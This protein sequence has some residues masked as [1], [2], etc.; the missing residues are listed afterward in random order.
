MSS[1]RFVACTLNLWGDMRLEEREPALRAFLS[2]SAPDLLGVQELTPRLLSIV[3]SALPD[4]D[5]VCDESVAGWTGESNLFWARDQ[6]RATDHGAEGF[7]A[8]EPNR[9]VFWVRLV[10]RGDESRSMLFATVH[11]TACL[12]EP[13]TSTG[14]NPRPGQATT[15]AE[16]LLRVARPDEPILFLGDFNEDELTFWRMERAGFREVNATL[17]RSPQPTSPSFPLPGRVPAVDDW[18][19]FRGPLQPMSFEV[20]QCASPGLPP[21]DHR[22]ALATFRWVES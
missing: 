5:C 21:S 2:A 9:R 17:G 10:P 20:A 18:I 22:P 19:Y 14:Q 13:E 3:G 7:G 8:L 15:A 16:S 12:Y 11:L 4:H 6:F 1:S